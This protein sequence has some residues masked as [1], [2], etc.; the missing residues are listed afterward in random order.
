MSRKP[1]SSR[2]ARGAPSLRAVFYRWPLVALP[3][4]DRVLMA[5]DG[6]TLRHLTAPTQAA[7]NL[8]DRRGVIAYAA[9]HRHHGRDA[10]AGPPPL[11]AVVMGLT[12]MG[13]RAPAWGPSRLRPL[14]V[15]PRAT[16]PPRS[17]TPAPSAPPR[18]SSN[19]AP[20]TPRRS[21]AVVPWSWVI[22]RVSCC[23]SYC[24]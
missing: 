20:G 16:D 13:G 19:F 14:S 9:L 1:L 12:G 23:S 15:R 6:P 4:H 18:L 3:M 17:P 2:Q 10:L 11:A 5:L 21:G 24:V 7:Y 22:Q 8:P